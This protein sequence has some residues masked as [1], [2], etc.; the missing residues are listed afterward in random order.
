MIIITSIENDICSL[1]KKFFNSN[2]V[3]ASETVYTI[4]FNPLESVLC[5]ISTSYMIS[6]QTFL[7]RMFG[8]PSVH[9]RCKRTKVLS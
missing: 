5:I 9:I 1:E 3:A 7:P 6:I 2:Y 8:L 4:W